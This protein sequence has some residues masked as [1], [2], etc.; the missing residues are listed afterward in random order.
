MKLKEDFTFFQYFRRFWKHFLLCYFLSK[1][2]WIMFTEVP[3]PVWYGFT[4]MLSYGLIVI[5]PIISKEIKE[6]NK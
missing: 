5:F 4:T 6:D 3:Q 1:I 2:I